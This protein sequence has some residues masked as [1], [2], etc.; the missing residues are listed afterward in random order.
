MLSKNATRTIPSLARGFK[1][2]AQQNLKIVAALYEDPAE[3][4]T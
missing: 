4:N 2:T 1:A 3:G